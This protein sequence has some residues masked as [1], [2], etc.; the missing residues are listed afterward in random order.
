[1][2]SIYFMINALFKT[3]IMRQASGW[4]FLIS[5]AFLFTSNL[6][7]P[8]MNLLQF[9]AAILFI[10]CSLS[11][12]LSAYDYRFL[13]WGGITII[14]AYGLTS[15]SANADAPGIEYFGIITGLIAGLLIL[16]AAFQR[17]TGRQFNLPGFLNWLDRYPLASAGAIE[18]SG[19]VLISIGA[20]EAEDIRL[21]ITAILWTL[22]H[23]MLVIS[24][25]YLRCA[26]EARF[27]CD[28][29]KE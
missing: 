18:G 28:K 19:C 4:L 9:L 11:L 10:T 1:M 22:A 27:K 21:F 26:F 17:H 5:N 15:V 25:E 7:M 16:R 20:A 3:R 14:I 29:G 6:T 2:V 23:V 12:I 24:D 8:N 13:F